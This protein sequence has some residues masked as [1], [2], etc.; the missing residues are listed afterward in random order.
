M[1]ALLTK[2]RVAVRRLRR[3]VTIVPLRLRPI[4]RWFSSSS[5][6]TPRRGSRN[7]IGC[8]DRKGPLSRLNTEPADELC[9]HVQVMLL[10]SI[11][12]RCLVEVGG[13]I[14]AVRPVRTPLHICAGGLG[15]HLPPHPGYQPLRWAAT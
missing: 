5:G 6:P 10:K 1:G 15:A 2:L 4:R 12:R 8:R 13:G 7:I 11:S 14:G 9:E 3:E